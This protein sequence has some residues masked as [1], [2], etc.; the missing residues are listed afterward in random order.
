[1]V[2]VG[3]SAGVRC[4][5]SDTRAVEKA[6]ALGITGRGLG[7]LLLSFIRKTHVT[8]AVIGIVSVV[9]MIL[10]TTADVTGR[11]AFNHPIIGAVEFTQALLVVS[12]FLA[13]GYTQFWKQHI[14]ADL[15]V[16]KLLPPRP[17]AIAEILVLLFALVTIGFVTYGAVVAGAEST[18]ARERQAGLI[19]FPVWPGR[20]AVAIGLLFLCVQYVIDIVNAAA[21]FFRAA[22]RPT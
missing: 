3:I 4:S 17:R 10:A 22:K 19:T 6:T 13:L 20:L 2:E 18:I 5:M 8:L 1:M 9:L 12:A 14:L 11:A 15:M 16:G 21:S 7:G